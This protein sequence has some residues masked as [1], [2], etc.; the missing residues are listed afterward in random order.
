MIN[1]KISLKACAISLVVFFMLCGGFV[2]CE[3][4]FV[5]AVFDTETVSATVTQEVTISAPGEAYFNNQIPGVSGN[6]GSPSSAS[7]AWVVT[8]NNSAGYALTVSAS[9]T[10][11]LVNTGSGSYYFDDYTTTPTHNWDSGSISTGGAKFG[12]SVTSSDCVN[13]FVYSSGSCGGGN[14]VGACSAECWSGFN[15]TSPITIVDTDGPTSTSGNNDTVSLNA[16][17][18]ARFLQSGEY[19]ASITAT[20]SLN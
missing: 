14:S 8:T 19:T 2:V 6:P 5:S 10:P 11:A 18:N 7:L 13:A 16:E 3:P 9:A 4:S 20:V 17:S 15:S 1:K 12:F